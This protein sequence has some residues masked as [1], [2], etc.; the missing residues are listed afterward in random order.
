MFGQ[1]L[2]CFLV[3]DDQFWNV[4]KMG[5]GE[6][7]I[8]LPRCLTVGNGF[9]VELRN[10]ITDDGEGSVFRVNSVECFRQRESLRSI[11]ESYSVNAV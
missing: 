9:D 4:G 2:A 5:P 7:D 11:R 1:F 6:E 10:A 8:V 3:E